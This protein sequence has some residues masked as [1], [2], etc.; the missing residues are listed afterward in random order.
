[1]VETNVEPV[2][3]AL[4]GSDLAAPNMSNYS[5]ETDRARLHRR[6]SP[7]VCLRRGHA[8][9]VLHAEVGDGGYD[10]VL[11]TDGIVRHVQLKARFKSARG[12]KV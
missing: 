9:E 8:V 3:P 5:R 11:Q 6:T 7:G 10:L 2:A 12:R 1:M 4:L